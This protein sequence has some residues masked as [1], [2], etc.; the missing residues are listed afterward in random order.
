VLALPC[1]NKVFE[2]KCDAPEVGIGGILTQKGRPL[3]F[4][5][6]MLCESRRKYFTYDKEFYTIVRSLEH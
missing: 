6:K 5:S 4:F 3:A 2:V 1:F